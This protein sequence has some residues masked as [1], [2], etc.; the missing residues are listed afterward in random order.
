MRHVLSEWRAFF[1]PPYRL[2]AGLAITSGSVLTLSGIAVLLPLLISVGI[3]PGLATLIGIAILAGPAA[4]LF[5]PALLRRSGG[6]LRRMTLICAMIG[7]T[8]GLWLAPLAAAAGFDRGFVPLLVIGIIAAIALAGVFSGVTAANLQAWL[9]VSLLEPERRTVAPRVAGLGLAIGTLV[10]VPTSLVVSLFFTQFGPA[11]YVGPFLL[12]GLAGVAELA[13]LRRLPNPGRVRVPKLPPS[14]AR[15]ELGR[16]VTAA[17]LASFGAGISP[18]LSIYAMSGLGFSAGEA[19][20]LSAFVSAVSLIAST[21][22][23]VVLA[24]RSSSRLLRRA[25]LMLGGGWLLMFGALPF[26]P[27]ARLVFLAAA[28]AIGAGAALAQLATNE[29]LIRLAGADA[30]AFQG[31]FV[32][33]SA[34]AISLGQLIAA[35][36]LMVVPGLP[37]FGILFAAS[38]ASRVLAAER[39]EVSAVPAV[40]GPAAV[41]GRTSI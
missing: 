35:G 10:L 3:S 22:A 23:A 30:I 32:A 41:L 37:V 8:R 27:Y 39:L 26:S 29:R 12:A 2:Y 9:A 28:A 24:H 21:V 25:W 11:V 36:L 7:E 33:V 16:F 15:P 18:Y 34:T 14:G 1:G 20:A 38:G 13:I 17:A 4:Q 19:I 6:R 40:V 5:V 31:R